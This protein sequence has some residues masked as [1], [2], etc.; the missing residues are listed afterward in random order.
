M[1]DIPIWPTGGNPIP[2]ENE[3][4]PS[5]QVRT[6][7]IP[8]SQVRTGYPLPRSGQGTPSQ[9]RLRGTPHPGPRSG[10]GVPGVPP[11][12]RIGY[13]PAAGWG[14]PPSSRSQV[15]TGGETPNWNSMACT[16]YAAGGIPL[17]FT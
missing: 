14:T 6:G 3:G 12:S 9:V 5:S 8:P 13:P 17:A 10:W 7:G 1:G 16:C 11:A 2:G 15:R 4:V